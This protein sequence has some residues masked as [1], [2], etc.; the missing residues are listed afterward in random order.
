MPA[1]S[2]PWP[3]GLKNMALLHVL[4]SNR[5]Y[6]AYSRGK[7]SGSRE[8]LFK[9]QL[10]F[11]HIY[12]IDQ[13]QSHGKSRVERW[14]ISPHQVIYWWQSYTAK[15]MSTRRSKG[16]EPSDVIHHSWCS[17]SPLTGAM[18]GSWSNGPLGCP[19]VTGAGM[20]RTLLPSSSIL[21]GP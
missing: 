4:S 11:T 15:G 1:A 14:G 13:S 12:L 9:P 21:F 6:W 19:L 20:N 17:G 18:P 7:V 3:A 5:L 10:Y 8:H 16:L 2:Y